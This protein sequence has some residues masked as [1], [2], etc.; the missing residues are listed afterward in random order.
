MTQ[1]TTVMASRTVQEM[2][3]LRWK[4]LKGPCSDGRSAQGPVPVGCVKHGR[5][6]AYSHP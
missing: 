5:Q 4:K 2:S 1:D 6:D 3:S